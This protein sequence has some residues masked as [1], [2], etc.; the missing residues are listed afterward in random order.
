MGSVECMYIRWNERVIVYAV[1][2][3]FVLGKLELAAVS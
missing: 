3:L 2:G 1:K